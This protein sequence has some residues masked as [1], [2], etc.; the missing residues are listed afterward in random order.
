M[1]HNHPRA[2]ILVGFI[3]VLLGF[4]LPLLMVLDIL[5]STFLLNFFAFGSGV[6]GFLLG[7]V[8]MAYYVRLNRQNPQADEWKE[9][10][11]K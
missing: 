9:M 8:G 6:A 7:V 1:I 4:L 10:M 3:L 5:E 2:T 11:K